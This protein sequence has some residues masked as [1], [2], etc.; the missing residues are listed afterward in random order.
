MNDEVKWPD[1]IDWET[2]FGSHSGLKKVLSVGTGFQMVPRGSVE[3]PPS[4]LPLPSGAGGLRYRVPCDKKASSYRLK[5]AVL[6][7]SGSN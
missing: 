6:N 1:L 3:R 2:A 7:T 5:R 4:P